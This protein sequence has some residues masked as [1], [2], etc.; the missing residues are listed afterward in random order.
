MRSGAECRAPGAAACLQEDAEMTD[1]VVLARKGTDAFN[2]RDIVTARSLLASDVAFR[3]T[4]MPEVRGVDAA[5]E[6]N[7]VWWDACSDARS[8]IVHTAVAGGDTVL[9]HGRF[10]GTHDGTL[11]TPM[12]EIDPTGKTIEGPFFQCF[13]FAG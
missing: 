11:R 7:K 6:F 10:R 4:G 2:D 13:R 8:E 12:G 1:L 5:V 3:A 9:I